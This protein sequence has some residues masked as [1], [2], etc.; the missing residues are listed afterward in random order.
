[1]STRMGFH[2]LNPLPNGGNVSPA[3]TNPSPSGGGFHPLNPLPNGGGSTGPFHPLNPLPNGSQ[4]DSATVRSRASDGHITVREAR[5]ISKAYT[6][7]GTTNAD[8][9]LKI[10]SDLAFIIGSHSGVTISKS[11]FAVL[12][13][14]SRRPVLMSDPA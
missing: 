11:A 14:A 1:M 7:T 13:S 10:A 6:L 3:P 9:N 2:P 4:F 5:E 8:E 12:L